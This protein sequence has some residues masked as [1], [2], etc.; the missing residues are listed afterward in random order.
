[1]AFICRITAF[2]SI[3]SESRLNTS[4]IVG[5]YKLIFKS[6]IA[7]LNLSNNNTSQLVFERKKY[8]N[9]IN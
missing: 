2:H 7:Q 1:M 4:K 9:S 8:Q 5:D 6:L 3:E